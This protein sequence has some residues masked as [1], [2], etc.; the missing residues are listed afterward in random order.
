[1]EEL[2]LDLQ[3]TPNIVPVDLNGNNS[4]KTK[5]TITK[6]EEKSSP[7]LEVKKVNSQPSL[8]IFTKEEVSNSK[9]VQNYEQMKAIVQ[10][11]LK[12][13]LRN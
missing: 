11:G 3:S 2:N 12:N 10:E 6:S 4:D 13:Q 8:S 9:K 7:S 5:I 1:M